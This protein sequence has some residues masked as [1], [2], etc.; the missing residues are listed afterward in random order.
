MLAD[1]TGDGHL[2]LLGSDGALLEGHGDGTFLPLRLVNMPFFVAAAA[3]DFDCD[4]LVD[5][6]F[7]GDGLDYAAM[8]L[9]N[10]K[11]PGPESGPGRRPL[12]RCHRYI[13]GSVHRGRVGVDAD[14]LWTIRNWIR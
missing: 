12:P 5:L 6:V 3:A 13:L 14:A 2:D 4:G 11:A 9:F 8:V 1:F 10:R 7:T